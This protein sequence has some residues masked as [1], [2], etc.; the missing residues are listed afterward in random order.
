MFNI[1]VKE[2]LNV[3]INENKAWKVFEEGK[4]GPINY[5]CHTDVAIVSLSISWK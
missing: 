2:K 1:S 4:S 3:K 5:Y